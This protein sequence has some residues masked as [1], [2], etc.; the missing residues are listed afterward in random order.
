M[1]SGSEYMYTSIWEKK[2]VCS[3]HMGSEQLHQ[4][5]KFMYP[6]VLFTSEG[7]IVRFTASAI[8]WSSGS[9]NVISDS[10]DE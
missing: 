1:L 6:G 2:V 5:E 9:S 3:T 4:V 8:V 10:S 7:K